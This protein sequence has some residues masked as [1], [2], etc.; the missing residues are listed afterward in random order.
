FLVVS[1]DRWFLEHVAE[2]MLDL[3][4]VHP[5]G[6]FETRGRYSEFLERK[7]AALHEQAQWQETLGNR[8]RRELDWLRHGA[9][10]RTTK[11]QARIQE[12][13]RLFEELTAVQNR[14]D[15]RA[16]SIDF[17]A[18]DRRTKRLVVAGH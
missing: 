15:T 14:Q 5:G 11:S 7:D 17:V 12:A 13:G 8:V 10:A 18:T 2:R 4:P 1:H 16:A 9:K 3:D 6:F